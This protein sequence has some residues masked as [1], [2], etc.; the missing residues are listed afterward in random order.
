MLKVDNIILILNYGSKME[1]WYI[2]TVV[3]LYNCFY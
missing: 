3:R 1:H 2:C